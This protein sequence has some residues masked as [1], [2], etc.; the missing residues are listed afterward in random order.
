MEKERAERYLA[1]AGTII[2]ALDAAGAITLINGKGCEVL[3][4]GQAELAGRNWF[5]TVLPA[6]TREAARSAHRDVLQDL[7]RRPQASKARSSRSRADG[8]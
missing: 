3:E 4:Y 5:D 7:R 6:E 2:V 1:I 8:G